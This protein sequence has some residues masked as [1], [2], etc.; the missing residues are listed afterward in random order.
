[1]SLAG[2]FKR[3]LQMLFHRGRFQ[4]ELDEEMR[5]HVELRREQQMAAGAAPEA[6][7][8]AALRRFGNTTRLRQESEKAWG[9]LRGELGLRGQ[10]R[11]SN[12]PA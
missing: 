5:L 1:M 6:A 10:R 9:E 7:R 12:E 3:R 11:N 4:R 2:E 8:Q